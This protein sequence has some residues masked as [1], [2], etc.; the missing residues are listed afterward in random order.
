[1]VEKDEKDRIFASHL[2]VTPENISGI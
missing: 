1:M 2:V